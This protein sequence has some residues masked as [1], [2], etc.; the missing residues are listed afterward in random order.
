MSVRLGHD[1]RADVA[2]LLD[3]RGVPG[4][5]H[6]EAVQIIAGVL[7][8]FPRVVHGGYQRQ[9][10]LEAGDV[11]LLAVPRRGVHEPRAALG[12]DVL[13]ADH[14]GV[15][16]AIWVKRSVS[17]TSYQS[18]VKREARVKSDDRKSP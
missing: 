2:K 16:R 11:I 1:E 13:S 12:G 9:T 8:E 4:V 10:V 5:E 15:K 17:R 7:R 14:D 6:R 3:A 18:N